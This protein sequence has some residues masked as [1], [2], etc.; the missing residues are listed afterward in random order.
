[1][2]DWRDDKFTIIHLR[3]YVATPDLHS[4]WSWPTDAC[5]Y[6]QTMRFLRYCNER[7]DEWKANW[8]KVTLEYADALERGDVPDFVPVEI[9]LG[10]LERR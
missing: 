9:E 8:K 1:M 6:E 3:G 2:K 10:E 5:G 7:M 4:H